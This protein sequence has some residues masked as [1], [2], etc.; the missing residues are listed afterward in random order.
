MM[1]DIFT[2]TAPAR[3]RAAPTGSLAGLSALLSP[4][5]GPTGTAGG[6][7]GTEWVMTFPPR[8]R[9]RRDPL[10]GW[11]GG[12]DPLD[13]L[14]L[15]FP[16]RESAEDYARREGID[17]EVSGPPVLRGACA[18]RAALAEAAAPADPAL[19]WIWDGRLPAQPVASALPDA[20]NDNA[21][22]R[23]RAA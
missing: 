12:G 15:R 9:G 4:R 10:M 23:R 21:P 3:P 2:G 8:R 7:L 20:E 14:V 6:R 18:G 5:C 17:L 19:P 1:Q 13:S 16:N 11:W 22:H